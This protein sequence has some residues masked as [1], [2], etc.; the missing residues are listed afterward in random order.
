MEPNPFVKFI[1]KELVEALE[2]QNDGRSENQDRKRKRPFF[3]RKDN[4]LYRWFGMV[5]YSL[6]MWRKKQ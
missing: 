6:K 2:K 4:F 3:P 1:T 5:P